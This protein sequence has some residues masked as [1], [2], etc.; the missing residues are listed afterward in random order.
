DEFPSGRFQFSGDISNFDWDGDL[1]FFL[2]SNVRNGGFGDLALYNTFTHKAQKAAPYESNC[3][4]RDAS[5]SPD[6]SHV[7]F[8]FQ[9]IRLGG[10]SPINL[11]IIPA[12]SISTPRTL[13]P[14]LLPENFFTDRNEAPS[15]VMRPA[16]P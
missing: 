7:I 4:Y 3:C 6:G 11:Y 15:P 10:E 9:D 12:D 14:L 16:Q 8:A 13:E 2:T 5:F 1:L